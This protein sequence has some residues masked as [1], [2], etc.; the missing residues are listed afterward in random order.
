MRA[1]QSQNIPD[2]D[3]R[4]S[5]P[6]PPRGRH[7]GSHSWHLVEAFLVVLLL[8]A[9]GALSAQ[10]PGTFRL[11][12]VNVVGSKRHEPPEIARAAGLKLAANLTLDDLKEA[13]DKLSSTGVFAQV[14][15]RYQT[16]GNEMTV[17]FALQDTAGM[18]PCSFEN[19]VWFS[20]Q[21]LVQELR[22]RVPLF[23]G[24]VPAAGRMLEVI[25]TQLAA[26]LEARGLHAQVQ[27]TPEGSIGGPV[28]SMQF[29]EVGVPDP[30]KKIEFTGVE[31]VDV[32]WLVEAARPLLDKDF[33]TSFIRD[34]S[35]DSISAV[36]QQR[37]YLRAA[38]GDPVPHLLAND[39]TPNAVA[40][41]VPVT[42]GEQYRLKEVVWF[43]ESAISYKELEKSLHAK[44][45]EPL[46][47][48][49][50]EHDVLSLILLFHPK[51]YLM[52]D[53]TSEAALD[54]ATHTAIYRVQIRQGD[55]YRMGKLEIAGLDEARA[56]SLEQLSLLRSG[57]PYDATYWNKFLQE[58]GRKLPPS[59]SGWKFR[60][61]QTI[62]SDT[63]TVDVR[64]TFVRIAGR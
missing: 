53:A 51:G 19:F 8:A 17:T 28:R 43:G 44:S 50:L 14:A 56:R 41:T 1:I 30:V 32:A 12:S 64:L 48:V 22:A 9:R 21:E 29:R 26:M 49:Q 11:A 52:A 62:H 6:S 45:G 18:L 2:S 46:N 60:P 24:Y 5:V 61:D 42:E 40:V 7:A 25:S 4:D 37:G 3:R 34:Y 23:D 33:D 10:G 38:F 57:D 35:R 54:D 47:A 13:A 16:R 39:P 59:P 31:K 55:L 36:Y 27:F 63:K 58:I 20:P 15:Y